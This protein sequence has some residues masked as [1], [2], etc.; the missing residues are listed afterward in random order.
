VAIE[1]YLSRGDRDLA[2]FGPFTK[3]V[4]NRLSDA[5]LGA[6][7]LRQAVNCY[8]DDAGR[9]SRRDGYSRVE[10]AADGHSLYAGDEGVFFV[11]GALLRAYSVEADTVASLRADLTAAARMAWMEVNGEVYYS[12]GHQRG[13]IRDA[14]LRE[15]GVEVP[16]GLPALT[17]GAGLLPSGHY[18]VLCT[19]VND[20]GEES[21]AGRAVGITL[22]TDG[23]V[24]AST[25]PQPTSSEVAAINVYMTPTNG[26]GVFYRAVSV[27]VGTTSVTLTSFDPA[28]E[29]K[30][31]FMVPPPAGNVLAYAG[32][33]I[34]VADGK[35]VWYTEPYALGRCAIQRSFLLFK[36]DVTLM[37]GT[38]NG[39]YIA[40]G[41]TYFM[42]AADPAT[43]ELDVRL[44]Y[45]AAFGSLAPM[46]TYASAEAKWTW[47]SDRG[48]VI[49]DE[50]GKITN[51]QDAQLVLDPCATGAS[52]LVEVD[53]MK[54]IVSLGVPKAD[55]AAEA[56]DFVEMEVRRRAS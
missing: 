39:L 45:G 17:S 32:G 20:E 24:Q 49:A 15:W 56:R 6:D 37:A 26:A 33:R 54:Q 4:N 41:K 48:Q 1:D 19:F 36:D 51:L 35:I 29:L 52:A 21:G 11:D 43:A 23:S 38:K 34:F 40:A 22:V 44:P 55:S 10:V 5:A 2:S 28:K 18:E 42:S 46:P 3:G 13:K 12:N 50:N 53:G 47:R 16:A 7:M 31:Q 30:T 8:L 14:A 27:A 9:L 25:L